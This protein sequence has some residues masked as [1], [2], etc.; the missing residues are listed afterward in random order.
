MV[1]FLRGFQKAFLLLVVMGA[2]LFPLDAYAQNETEKELFLIAQKSFDDGFYD[3]AIRYIQKFVEQFPQSE[4][5]VQAKLLLGQCYFFKGQYLKAFDIFEKLLPYSEF[6]DATLFWLGETHL[7][8]EDYKQ[9]EDYYRQLIDIYPN[10]TYVP[11]AYHSLAWT[12]FERK[13]YFKAKEAFMNLLQ[14]FP[15]HL[16]SEEAFFKV[17]ECEYFLG[18]Y[19]SAIQAF[20]KY[21]TKYSQLDRQA[22]AY[23]YIAESYYYLQDFLTAGTYYAKAAE[24]S[25]DPHVIFMSK[26]SMGW[27]YLKLGKY[28]LSEKYFNEAEKLATERKILSDDIYLGKAN[29]YSEMENYPQALM[30]Y[31]TLL[32]KFPQSLRFAEAYLGKANIHYLQ[33]N[34]DEAIKAYQKIVER[35]ARDS[36][37]QEI[38][39]KAYYGLAWTYLKKGQTDLA[40]QSFQHV[41][42]STENKMVKISALT[43]MGDAYHDVGE[44]EKAITI[45]DRILSKYPDSLYTDYVQFRQGLALL[46]LNRVEAALLSFQTLQA[47]F[48]TSKHLNEVR[49]YLAVVYFQK[50]DWSQAVRYSQEYLGGLPRSNTLAIEA[51][52]LLG[53]SHFSLKDS[54]KALTIFQEL[55]KDP[56]LPPTM[57]QLV[58]LNIGKCFFELGQMKPAIQQFEMVLQKYPDS[59]AAQEA[60]LELGEYYFSNQDFLKAISYYEKFLQQFP[61]AERI[62]WVYYELGRAYQA[63]EELDRAV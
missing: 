22:Q 40:I 21:L 9:A 35:G 20:L 5:N 28:D 3:V 10:S 24:I 59:V 58:E 54:S 48:P 31:E 29:L 42:D 32:E 50:R 36:Q 12:H 61:G 49:Y 51:Q 39:E 53:L 11:Q 13:D 26:L 15:A 41:L 34:Y 30:A 16:L 8:G 57:L 27:S 4:K 43:Q 46:K 47:N 25:Y 14:K 44:F 37:H 18:Q 2:L 17:A 6:K 1:K 7:K 52:Y 56:S 19:E 33:E 60:F 45:Y 55:L 62:S 38:L 23:F 63:H